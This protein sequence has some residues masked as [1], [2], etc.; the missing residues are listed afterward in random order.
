MPTRASPHPDTYELPPESSPGP[1]SQADGGQFR[2]G[3]KITFAAGH[4]ICFWRWVSDIKY[5]NACV[6]EEGA[7]AAERHGRKYTA[8]STA[9]LY[10]SCRAQNLDG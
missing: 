2:K 1:A 7:P 9:M 8:D 4:F 6:L 5:F 10:P 3:R